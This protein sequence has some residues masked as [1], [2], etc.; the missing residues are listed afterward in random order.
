VHACV[1]IGPA[2]P[3]RDGSSDSSVQQ[4]AE[5][6]S[7]MLSG[8]ESHPWTLQRLCELLLEPQKQYKRLH[9]L[10]SSACWHYSITCSSW[11]VSCCWSHRSSTSVCAKW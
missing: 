11:C 5:R 2:R 6:F 1:Q 4:L 9:K 3:I 10:V 7:R 8:F